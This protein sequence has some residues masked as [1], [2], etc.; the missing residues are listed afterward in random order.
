MFLE[1]F[2]TILQ[3]HI[4]THKYSGLV[5]MTKQISD[6]L[7]PERRRLVTRRNELVDLLACAVTQDGAIQLIKDLYLFRVSSTGG[8]IH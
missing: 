1:N 7:T 6:Q 8:P 3:I 5:D 2:C 4:K